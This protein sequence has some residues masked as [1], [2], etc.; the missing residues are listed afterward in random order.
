M[1]CA[2]VQIN[3]QKKHLKHHNKP[4]GK[5][6]DRYVENGGSFDHYASQN[7]FADVKHLFGDSST[8]VFSPSGI[9]HHKQNIAPDSLS[10]MQTHIP[11]LHI[12]YSHPSDQISVCPTPS[13]IKS[14]N[15]GHMSPSPKESSN[16]S[17]QV[18]SMESS[19]GPSF[20]APS[21]T[22]NEKREKPFHCQDVQATLKRNFKHAN[23]ANPMTFGNSLSLQKRVHQSELAI[24]G[25]SEVEGVSIGVPAELD[26]SNVHESSCMSS[27]LDEISLEAT[28]FR[29]LQQVMDK[30]CV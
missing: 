15:N 8:R 16:A 26:S 11:Y 6:K 13:G 30:V 3:L 2:V 24:E 25:Q 1:N 23:T 20:E 18:Q 29:Q 7:E 14:E 10:C 27:A 17:N 22:T 19:H 5:R 12:N 4:E 28:S 21:V 9:Q